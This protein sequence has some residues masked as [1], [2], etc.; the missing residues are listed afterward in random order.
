LEAALLYS[1]DIILENSVSERDK[2]FV[3]DKVEAVFMKLVINCPPN[4]PFH[5]I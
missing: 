4:L 5:S 3:M 2:G 1:A